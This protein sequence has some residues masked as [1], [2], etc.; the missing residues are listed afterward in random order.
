MPLCIAYS[1]HPLAY[2]ETFIKNHIEYLKPDFTLSGG[3]YPYINQV[4]KSIFPFPFSINLVRGG[5]KQV[6]PKIY[7]N[8]YQNTLANFLIKNK[9]DT[10]LVEYGTTGACMLAGVKKAKA[11]LFVHFHGYDASVYQVLE[12]YKESYLSMADYAEKIIVVS[13]DMKQSLINT[14]IKPDKLF[15]IPCG[16]DINKFQLVTAL[17]NNFTFI[18]VGRFTP[19]KAPDITIK[20]FSKVYAKYPQAKLIM[21]GDGVML[22]NCKELSAS[23]NLQDTV[24]FT[25]IQTSEQIYERLKKAMIYIQHSLRDTTGDSEGTPNSILEASATGLPIV[26][27]FHAGIKEAVIHNQTGYLVEEGD[28][29]GMAD[30]M[31]QLLENYELSS[32]MGKMGRKHIEDNYSVEM[33]IKKIKKLLEI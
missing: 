5:I 31:I 28:I 24:E 4:E 18:F 25:G 19:K 15:N 8:Q 9:I 10:V 20:A 11:K 3:S 6:L 22:Q 7:S 2:S 26:S 1:N 30:Y 14:G 12:D 32:N 17:L 23:L 16:I 27:T 33:Q 29:E 21:I 13:D